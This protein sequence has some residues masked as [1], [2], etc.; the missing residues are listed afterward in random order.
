MQAKDQFPSLDT[1]APNAMQQAVLDA[2]AVGACVVNEDHL[3][4]ANITLEALL[5]HA[6]QGMRA[7]R[8]IDFIAPES[9][10]LWSEWLH[11]AQA[12]QGAEAL[13]VALRHHH[14]GSVVWVE[15]RA[16]RLESGMLLVTLSDITERW[17]LEQCGHLR[18]HVLERL[19]RG[20]VLESVL[21]SIV[22]ATEELVPGLH[23]AVML[24]AAADAGLVRGAAPNVPELMLETLESAPLD[25]IGARYGL[26]LQAGE[27]RTVKNVGVLSVD[28]FAASAALAGFKACWSE[29]IVNAGGQ[30]TA[31]FVAYCADVRLLSRSAVELL[32]QAVKLSG[33]AIERK[34]SE[35][36]LQLAAL[37]YRTSAE[38][39]MV[40][41]TKARV[42]AVNPALVRMTGYGADEL[43]GQSV[44]ALR[45]LRDMPELMQSLCDS[46]LAQTHW[47]G[48]VWSERKNG[49]SFVCWV[50]I[51]A[52]LDEA[53]DVQ[54]RVL[55]FSDITNRKQSEALIWRQAN[56]DLLTQLP[57]RN[58][59]QDRLAQEMK[60]ATY[61]GGSLALLSIDLDN[62]KEVNATQ[63]QS[64]GDRVLREAAR[65]IAQ[66]VGDMHTVA[67]MGS[68]EFVVLLAVLDGGEEVEC[69]VQR[70][71]SRL[72]EPYVLES[73]ETVVSAS[74]GL[75]YAQ[76]EMSG[77]ELL[78]NAGQA[79][80]LAKSRGGSQYCHFTAD[81]RQAAL[82][83]HLLTKDLRVAV[84][85]Q[86]LEL[87][88][89]PIVDLRTGRVHKAEALLRWNHPTRGLVGPSDFIGLAEQTGLIVE[90]GNWV[91][92]TALRCVRYW[93]QSYDPDF[94]LSINKSP[95]QF[96]RSGSVAKNWVRQLRAMD[97]P[98]QA[99][100]VEITEGLM[101]NSEPH[102]EQ[103]M[104]SYR[105]AGIPLA[106]DDFGTG[107][108]AMS[109]LKKFR[110]NCLKI[111]QSFVRC[112]GADS[113]DLA[114]PEA[115]VVMAHRL[116][117]QVVAEGVETEVQRQLLVAMGCDY[118]QGYLFARPMPAAEFEQ[119]LASQSELPIRPALI[120][121]SATAWRTNPEE[122]RVC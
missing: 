75:A 71:L 29:S 65:R 121:A 53:G 67:R 79:M 114:L 49:E 81:L 83:R 90:I 102:I 6:S 64:Q 116:G 89:Q 15:A 44:H 119:V 45:I 18:D 97:L 11:S 21:H 72:S 3:L 47:E 96:D 39:M 50:S 92:E 23:C 105:E 118:G 86:Q 36:E 70:L 35:E 109:Y 113:R 40:V 115:I 60:A 43:V 108:S 31:V 98:A 68:N 93:R 62:F 78:N 122:S 107:Y 28:G 76:V 87:Y 41:D 117:L 20:A 24:K 111:D 120:A 88:F 58:M 80:R 10:R 112:L 19:A 106:I 110:A 9:L 63:G 37:V 56:Y 8:F 91:F 22:F 52:G 25:Q 100:V 2:L 1:D 104:A 54:R 55:L 14:A 34:H 38:G 30:V 26:A 84:E 46:L 4:F 51:N 74:I 13:R 101:L 33:L 16:K 66:G 27:V 69:L 94:Q 32:Q 61:R 12:L 82:E 17:R 99:I 77:Q 7:L 103:A 42:L 85:Q 57:N 59:L 48:E 5:G 73:I 95:A